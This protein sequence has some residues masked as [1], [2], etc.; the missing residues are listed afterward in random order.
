MSKCCCR[1]VTNVFGPTG[2]QG[3]PGLSTQTGATGPQGP[4]G[5]T[6]PGPPGPQG[7]PGGI[8]PTGP[9]G[10]IGGLGPTGPQGVI[11]GL[12]PT[13]AQGA[14]GVGG[15][16][17][18]NRT[19]FVDQMY[20]TAGGIPD[21]LN[22]PYQ[23]LAQAFAAYVPANGPATIFVQPGTYVGAGNLAA[24]KL[25]YHF[26]SNTTVNVTGGTTLF[27]VAAGTTFGVTGYCNFVVPLSPNTFLMSLNNSSPVL[28]ECDTVASS[29]IMAPA[30][31]SVSSSSNLTLHIR[32]SY[33]A[34]G[35]RILSNAGTVSSLIPNVFLSNTGGM[36]ITMNGGATSS[37]IETVNSNSTVA[38]II[39]S[40]QIKINYYANLL[41][42]TQIANVSGGSVLRLD[43]SKLEIQNVTVGSAFTVSGVGSSLQYNGNYAKFLGSAG[44]Q[45]L[46]NSTL[47][48]II[49]RV[50]YSL[51]GFLG[52]ARFLINT[53]ST[54][55]CTIQDF[56]MTAAGV[57]IGYVFSIDLP[58][59][60]T[61]YIQKVSL[62][63]S[64]MRLIGHTNSITDVSY[65]FDSITNVVPTT[66]LPLI[67]IQAAQ[68][69]FIYLQIGLANVS[70]DNQSFVYI[71]QAFI[72]Y[73]ISNADVTFTNNV[74][75]VKAGLFM[76]S[77]SSANGRIGRMNC[78]G[79]V[80]I[81]NQSNSGTQE[82][83]LFFG[84]L[85]T[86]NYPVIVKDLGTSFFNVKGTLMD[87][88]GNTRGVSHEGGKL[89]IEV[90]NIKFETGNVF[91]IT[92]LANETSIRFGKATILGDVN[93]TFCFNNSNDT[94]ISIIGKHIEMGDARSM[95]FVA[96]TTRGVNW[97]SN[98]DFVEIAR[99][100]LVILNHPPVVGNGSYKFFFDTGI[101]DTAGFDA[102]TLNTNE[103][104]VDIWVKGYINAGNYPL[105]ISALVP[106]NRIRLINST[107]IAGAAALGSI[108]S[109]TPVVVL[110]QG[111]IASNKAPVAPASLLVPGNFNVN[112]SQI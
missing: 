77:L 35:R 50:E 52:T 96:P 62:N 2:P 85:S 7:P 54:T 9:Q 78:V 63:N 104:N 68:Q 100:P 101:I 86:T 67:S 73:N 111:M 20:G 36:F 81:N 108:F 44:F 25:T 1:S 10:V 5:P 6:T 109:A 15:L 92:S 89:S 110:N 88:F 94:L 64:G 16:V 53:N 37:T 84:L 39:G 69:G 14:T 57:N 49:R 60:H 80:C 45:A 105:V 97:N 17:N 22:N 79:G 107:L 83:T 33:T 4:P 72:N 82:S 41:A 65:V 42:G 99:G 74:G 31:I 18:I 28:F 95:L 51:D 46:A 48:I 103:T 11:G 13:G 59:S 61:S 91:Y 58:V 23:T 102:I 66:S 76:D 21:S 71:D 38:G 55:T 27:T 93:T 19:F 40:G 34:N 29:S 43:I 8:G 47:D 75:T 32:R 106:S 56:S 98:I 70:I 30:D 3:P 112:A 24:D 87:I 90:D 12:G 26:E